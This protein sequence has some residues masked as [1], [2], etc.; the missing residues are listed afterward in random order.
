AEQRQR[1]EDQERYGRRR[2]G[3][4]V[5]DRGLSSA[6]Q[7]GQQPLPRPPGQDLE[8]YGQRRA[9]APGQD[10]GPGDEMRERTPRVQAEQRAG[11]QRSLD[12]SATQHRE[13]SAGEV[14]REGR[15]QRGP[16]VGDG[17][18]KRRAGSHALPRRI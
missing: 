4:E 5:Q 1:M 7:G 10:G 16:I 13:L 17:Q 2:R 6:G 18:L 3:R 14:G 11:D 15:L 8:G 12:V 9:T